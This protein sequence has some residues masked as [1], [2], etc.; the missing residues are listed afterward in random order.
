MKRTTQTV[1]SVSLPPK[2]IA[3]I[4]ARADSLDLTRSQYLAL[5]AKHDLT[6]L[7]PL[8]LKIQPRELPAT[9]ELT[10][11][12]Y[13]FLIAAVPEL[14]EYERQVKAG[15]PPTELPPLPATVTLADLWALFLQERQSILEHKWYLSE[16]EHRD[17]G[18]ELAIRDW[19]QKHAAKWVED[20]RPASAG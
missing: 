17:V 11:D 8:T 12:A 3:E 2:L 6:V 18:I 19:L 20:H 9:I 7:G 14:L 4:D 1:I 16:Q 10:D 13:D 5:L 15:N